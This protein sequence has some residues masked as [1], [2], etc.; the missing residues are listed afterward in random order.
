MQKL[1]ELVKT[2]CIKRKWDRRGKQY[3]GKTF[4]CFIE[5]VNYIDCEQGL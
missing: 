2:I 1:T 4:G 3:L 5:T